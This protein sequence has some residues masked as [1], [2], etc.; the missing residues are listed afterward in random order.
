[1]FKRV[2]AAMVIAALSNLIFSGCTKAVRVQPDKVTEKKYSIYSVD[3]VTGEHIEFNKSGGRYY[4]ATQTIRG[5]DRIGKEVIVKY[6]EIRQ[7][8]IRKFDPIRTTVWTTLSLGIIVGLLVVAF[9]PGLFD[10]NATGM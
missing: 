5:I 9:T 6:S 7:A 8:R 10:V 4:P 3:L 1:M 2:I